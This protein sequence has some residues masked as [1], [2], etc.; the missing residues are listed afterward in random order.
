[1]GVP[2]L[3]DSPS[4]QIFPI[5]PDSIYTFDNISY[6]TT[7]AFIHYLHR[8]NQC[9]WVGTCD[10]YSIITNSCCNTGAVCSVAVIVAHVAKERLCNSFVLIADLACRSIQHCFVYVAHH[11]VAAKR[12]K[13]LGKQKT[14]TRSGTR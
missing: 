12:G 4:N 2:M 11:D 1:M 6:V 9:V 5:L 8:H 14:H 10:T 13:V 7:T 3:I